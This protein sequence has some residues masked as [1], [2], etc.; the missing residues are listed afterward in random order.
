MINNTTDN[1]N[2]AITGFW[3]T[4]LLT[5]SFF[6][7]SHIAPTSAVKQIPFLRTNC[8]NRVLADA[9]SDLR[10]Q[11]SN[12]LTGP[13]DMTDTNALIKVKDHFLSD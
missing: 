7:R 3:S 4:L 1:I 13:R 12:S 9:A 11:T 6:P 5:T 8:A 2:E 10:P